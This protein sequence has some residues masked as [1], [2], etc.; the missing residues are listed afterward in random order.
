MRATA[1]NPRG[2]RYGQV[3][4][5]LGSFKRMLSRGVSDRR[6]TR[7]ARVTSSKPSRVNGDVIVATCIYIKVCIRDYSK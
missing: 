7:Y 2:R 4:A 1:S 5:K 3:S 6:C